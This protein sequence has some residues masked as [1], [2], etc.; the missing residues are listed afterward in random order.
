MKVFLAGLE[1]QSLVPQLA[2]AGI[3]VVTKPEEAD[4]I[5]CHG[6]DGTLIGAE[7]E[8]PGVPK[9]VVRPDLRFDKCPAHRP[10]RFFTRLRE[11]TL[12]RTALP[13]LEVRSNGHRLLAV[14]D[15]V[16]HNALVTSAVRYAVRIDG[17]PYSGTIIGDGLVVSTPFGSSAYYKS[18]TRSVLRVGIGLAFNNST[19]AVSHLVLAEDARISLEI[20][21]GPALLVA[22]NVTEPLPLRDGDGATIAMAEERAHLWG[23]DTLLCLDCRQKDGG[24]PAGLLHIR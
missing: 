24:R 1:T 2:A 7:R 16:M 22:D 23:I 11:G 3:A 8:Y 13:K 9:V 20:L 19:E 21:R 18:I 17:V 5:V 6:G 10:E 14:N 4:A 12:S 15:I